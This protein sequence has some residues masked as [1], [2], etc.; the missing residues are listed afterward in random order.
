VD[1]EDEPQVDVD[2]GYI[3]ALEAAVDG[4]TSINS[5]SLTSISNSLN[6]LFL[7]SILFASFYLSRA[8][9]HIKI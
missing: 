8:F 2:N 1:E 6:M 5:S 4:I 9:I 7:F 3:P